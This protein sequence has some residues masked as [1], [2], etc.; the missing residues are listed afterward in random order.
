MITT[1]EGIPQATKNQMETRFL[2]IGVQH[3][4][5]VSKILFK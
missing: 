3:S 4:R 1:N 5:T 2:G